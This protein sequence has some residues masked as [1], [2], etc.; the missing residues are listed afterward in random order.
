MGKRT[1]RRPGVSET[2]RKAVQDSGLSLYRMAKDTGVDYAVV[3]RFAHG[4]SRSVDLAT[5]DRLC[6]YLCLEL[7]RR[8]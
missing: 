2:L 4:R 5:L 7:T 8:K 1:T 3:W 6:S